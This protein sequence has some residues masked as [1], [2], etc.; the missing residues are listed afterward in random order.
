MPFGELP[1]PV[2]DEQELHRFIPH[3]HPGTPQFRPSYA[4]SR[5]SETGSGDAT[6]AG[7]GEQPPTA[8]SVLNQQA[9]GFMVT[10][11]GRVGL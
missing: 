3:V 1:R 11:H 10:V 9:V 6:P 8:A 4:G 7:K 5:R 2:T